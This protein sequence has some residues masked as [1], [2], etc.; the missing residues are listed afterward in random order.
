MKSN[1]FTEID[2]SPL[3]KGENNKSRKRNSKKKVV[4]EYPELTARNWR[5]LIG[6]RKSK[7][8]ITLPAELFERISKKE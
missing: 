8:S 7:F 5:K 1:N 4:E 3:S 2:T 6:K